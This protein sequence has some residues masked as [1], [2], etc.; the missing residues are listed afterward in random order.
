M[1][2]PPPS[3]AGNRVAIVGSRRRTDRAAVMAA[4]AELPP[5]TIVISGGSQGVDTWAV[6]AARARGLEVQE[7]KAPLAGAKGNFQ[8]AKRFDMRNRIIARECDRLIAFVSADRSGSTE[9]VI[10]YAERQK[11][12]VDIR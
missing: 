4:V 3:E 10:K 5:G 8:V 2:C 12:P 11:R 6:E 1:F 9:F 7:I